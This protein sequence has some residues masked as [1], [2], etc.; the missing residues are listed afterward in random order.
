MTMTQRVGTWVAATVLS[1]TGA[2]F[3]WPARRS[4]RL[5]APAQA[6]KPAGGMG[7]GIKVHGR[8][9]IEV[10]NPDG[11][12]AS[13]HEFQNDLYPFPPGRGELCLVRFA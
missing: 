7:E 12:L 6:A 11:S 10:R 3:R 4:G 9:T 5:R 8:W 13:R 1:V 2:W